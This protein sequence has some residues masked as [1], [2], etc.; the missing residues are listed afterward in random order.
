MPKALLLL[1]LA[2]AGGAVGFAAGGE[3]FGYRFQAGQVFAY[4]LELAWQEEDR[5]ERFVG[6]PVFEVKSI[7]EQ[8]RAELMVIGRLRS[9]TQLKGGQPKFND[10]REVWLGTR[11]VLDR[12]ADR[13]S[14]RKDR[15]LHH[16]PYVM[17]LFVGPTQMLFPPLPKGA[18]TREGWDR[19]AQLSETSTGGSP[20]FVPKIRFS[21]GREQSWRETKPLG[22]GTVNVYR[23]R[24][25]RTTEG[26]RLSWSY[27]GNSR[28]DPKLGRC[29]SLEATYETEASGRKPPPVRITARQLEGEELQKAID[30]GKEDW[31][32]LPVQDQP[33]EFLRRPVALKMPVHLKSAA[34]AKPG[35]VCAHLGEDHRYWLAQVIAP[36]GEREARIRYLG[37]KEE[38]KVAAGTLVHVPPELAPKPPESKK[39]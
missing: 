10:G 34:E 28:F 30:Q 15:N 1:S 27:K 26:E 39:P 8:G 18:A 21:A 17:R 35:L 4:R 23:E 11:F 36:V 32:L 2:L 19:T 13:V 14:G 33:V 38:M 24:G 9:V 5:L 12:L 6:T 7:N 37:S 3:E 16:L 31:R 25:F 29:V 20:I 22:D